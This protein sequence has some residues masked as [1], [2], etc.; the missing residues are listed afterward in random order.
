MEHFESI[1]S[2]RLQEIEGFFEPLE[3]SQTLE[4]MGEESESS[5]LMR[6]TDGSLRGQRA[7]RPAVCFVRHAGRRQR[8]GFVM[9]GADPI[10]PT[11]NR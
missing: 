3:A 7:L 6:K 4:R 10:E 2:F 8:L 5:S 1:Q 11:T 9:G